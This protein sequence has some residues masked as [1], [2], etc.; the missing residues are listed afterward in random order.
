MEFYH[1]P[2]ENGW[3]YG[4]KLVIASCLLCFLY[5]TCSYFFESQILSTRYDRQSED[6]LVRLIDNLVEADDFATYSTHPDNLAKV[7]QFYTLLNS[8]PEFNY[9]T[10]SGQPFS[11][12]N[13]EQV[14]Q[15][16]YDMNGDGIIDDEESVF[17]EGDIEYTNLKTIALNQATFAYYQLGNTEMLDWE[18]LDMSAG[19]Y[20]IM[21]G[22]NYADHY[23]IGDVI[24]GSYLSQQFSL[25]VVGFLAP[26]SSVFFNGEIDF[27]L[28]DYLLLPYPENVADISE[29]QLFERLMLF[30]MMNGD[31]VSTQ[32]FDTIVS[33]VNQVA[34]KSDFHE[35]TFINVPSFYIQN[36]N[37]RVALSENLNLIMILSSLFAGFAVMITTYLSTLL[38]KRRLPLYRIHYV[39]GESFA[40]LQR[41]FL[42]DGIY[43][44]WFLPVIVIA[45]AL[46]QKMFNSQTLLVMSFLILLWTLINLA[47]YLYQFSQT[48]KGGIFHD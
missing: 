15:F 32:D 41:R 35:Y 10:L 4:L 26:G 38:Y 33:L 2:K 21:L 1:N 47:I 31:I 34:N 22:N 14:N 13:F 40:K 46:N 36:N 8:H 6:T 16:R 5:T 7:S 45:F 9:L 27:Y 23:G 12:A 11:A 19:T 24:V 28:D 3:I 39:S 30:N 20:P 17:S 42:W 37:L 48:A 18:A 29:T 44:C 43:E 25:E